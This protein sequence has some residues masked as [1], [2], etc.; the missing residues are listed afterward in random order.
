MF[1]MTAKRP[2]HRVAT[3]VV[4][5]SLSL[6]LTV[7]LT[8]QAW[9]ARATVRDKRGDARAAW[10]ITKV[11]VANGERKLRLRVVYRGRLRPDLAPGL[12]TDVVLDMRSASGSV[13]EGDFD[14]SL[15][16]G[17]TDPRA[18]DGVRLM[19]SGSKRVRCRGLRG[20]AHPR[21]RIVTFAVPQR[22]FRD[23]AG[24]VRVAGYTYRVRGSA[25]EADYMDS[26]SRWIAKGS[27][28]RTLPRR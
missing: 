27:G 7:T 21:R 8:A 13:Y 22:C 16:A 1:S 17:S 10:D 14:V 6:V 25:K 3:T 20:R 18:P 9:G 19:A 5:I 24:R 26:W 2:V 4:A 12:L 11:V 28:S 23:Q 15:L